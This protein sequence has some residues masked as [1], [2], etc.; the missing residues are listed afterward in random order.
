MAGI[1]TTDKLHEGH[2]GLAAHILKTEEDRHGC[3]LRANLPQHKKPRTKKTSAGEDKENWN[4]HTFLLVGRY[5]TIATLQNSSFAKC[6][7]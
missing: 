7:I 5:N 6:Y 3:Q 2:G 1:K 4:P